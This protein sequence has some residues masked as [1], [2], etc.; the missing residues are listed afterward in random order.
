MT[1][2]LTPAAGRRLAGALAVLAAGATLTASASASPTST[3]GFPPLPSTTAPIAPLSVL[4]G[5][6][7][8][9]DGDIFLTP[10]DAAGT[11]AE[12]AEIA[13][14]SGQPLWFHQAP[15]GEVDADLRPQTLDGQK[16]LTFWE[17][18]NFGGLSNGT[19]YIYNDRY[20]Q[21]AAVH[22]GDGLATDGH[23]FLI[24]PW[25]TAF[26]ISYG[27]ATAD[28]SSVTGGSTDQTV[29]T[30]VVQEI[31]IH[32]GQ[33]LWSWNAAD[34]IP[35]SQ[36]E[37]PLP[38]ST[39]TPWDWFHVNAVKVDGDGSVL[40]D[41]RD[42]STFYKVSL[43]SGAVE[44]QIGGTKSS[45]KVGVAPGQTLDDAGQLFAWQ[46]DAEQIGPDT[47]SIFDD[48]SA[49]AANTGSNPLNDFGY[50]RVDIVKVDPQ[51]GTATLVAT[52]DQPEGQLASSQG[53]AQPLPG[54]GEF[55]GWGN[56]PSIS[57]FDGAGHLV[58]NAA[59]PTGVNSYR[60]YLLP[61]GGSGGGRGTGGPGGH[62]GGR[63]HGGGQG[64]GHGHGGGQGHGHGHG[65]GQG[66][67]HGGGHGR[68]Q[69]AHG[70]H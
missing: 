67:G 58:F 47:Y 26:V 14:P 61:W 65:G 18:T 13:S 4:S 62:G 50:S 28:V 1:R 32:T 51:A 49:G 29:V 43:Q 63:G 19:D 57:Q 54:G 11:Y 48:E 15:A 20:Q 40:I 22:A 64:H 66:H 24:S 56:L 5:G 31:D 6:Q 9:G 55:V 33:V 23:E 12:G 45:L 52:D 8:H 3:Q 36:S 59:F 27:T 2:Y 25:G 17:G 38:T 46:H 21:I 30:A 39:T 35:Y 10:T 42:T 37:E 7:A 34:H 16:V 53:N 70:R 41:A 69:G 44:E 68:G 60:A